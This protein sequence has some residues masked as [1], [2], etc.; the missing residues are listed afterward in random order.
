M[1]LRV[2]KSISL[3]KG[4]RLNVGKTGVGLSFG[5]RGLRYSINSS[6]RKTTTVGI[7]GTGVSYSTSSGSRSSRGYSSQA[8]N[9]RAQLQEQRRQQ[10]LEEAEQ[11]RLAVEEHENYL[12]VITGVH[13]E[14][15]EFVNWQKI[16]SIQAPYSPPATGPKRLKA[17]REYENFTPGFLEKIFKAMGDKR[18]KKLEAAIVEAE[19]QDRKEY[20][21]WQN[22]NIL[23][24]KVLE[25]ELDAYLQVIEEM[26]PLEDLLEFGSDFEFGADR[27][28]AVEVEFRVKADTVVPKQALSLTPT[29]RLSIKDM[30]K[31]RYYDLVQDYVC[32]CALRIARD[33][34]SLLPVEKVVVHAVDSFL[35]T[36]TGCNEDITILSAVF[37]RDTLKGLDFHLLDP[38]DALENFRHNMKFQKT[39]GFKAVERISKY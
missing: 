25:G 20:E 13:K 30:T 31:T 10:K 19:E 5:T 26:N 27:S 21:E 18:R 29:G 39:S 32:S 22:L 6:G 14:C 8:Y 34:T 37:D 7:P 12:E 15:D 28:T 3:G 16:N 36:S 35:N 23:S 9:R 4:V 33:I 2:R 17:M 1:G 11:N 38:S 24:G